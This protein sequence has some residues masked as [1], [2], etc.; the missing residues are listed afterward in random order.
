MTMATGNC[1]PAWTKVLA[2]TARTFTTSAGV[3]GATYS[4]FGSFMFVEAAS[5]ERMPRRSP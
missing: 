4:K 3:E 1:S 2:G 5:F